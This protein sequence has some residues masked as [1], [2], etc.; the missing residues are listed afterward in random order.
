[1][2]YPYKGKLDLAVERRGNDLSI[3]HGGTFDVL[4]LPPDG[5]RPSL[6]QKERQTP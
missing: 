6:A 1:M 5:S 4:T 2:L 3:R